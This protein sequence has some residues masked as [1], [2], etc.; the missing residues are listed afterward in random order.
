MNWLTNFVRPKIR[1]LYT[2]KEVPDNLWHKCPTCEAMIF[3]RD[4]E[5]NL[6]VCQHCGFHMRLD[7]DKRLK[8]LFDDEDFQVIE[9]PNAAALESFMADPVR[10]SLESTR[11]QCIARTELIEVTTISRRP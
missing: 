4:M 7:A 9:L 10:R 2:K 5:A 3:H 8:M 6:H 1:A 11:D